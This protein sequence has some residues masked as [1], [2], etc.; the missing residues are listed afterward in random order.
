M[1]HHLLK[2]YGF[3]LLALGS[4]SAPSFAATIEFFSPAGEIKGVRQVTARFSSAVVTF[5]DPRELAPFTIAC[6]PADMGSGKGRW[7]DTRNWVFDFERDLPA[8]VRC[9]FKLNASTKTLK[10]EPITGTSAFAFS[11]GGPAIVQSEPYDG[12]QSPKIK[13]FCWR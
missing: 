11:T 10:G 8:G 3:S 12:S 6:N 5:G 9:E 1:T 4:L 13:H 7:A 2:F